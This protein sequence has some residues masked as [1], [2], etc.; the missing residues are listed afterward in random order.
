MTSVWNQLGLPHKGWRCVEVIDLRDDENSPEETDY[1]TCEMC[2]NERIRFVHILEHD[3]F[4]A[5]LKVGCVCAENLT[6]DYINP[7]SH[8]NKLKNKANR[9]AK[10]LTRKWRVSSQGNKFLNIDGH[11]LCVF[12]DKFRSGHWKYKI[13]KKFSKNS[14]TSIT[15]AKLALFEEF[16]RLTQ[17]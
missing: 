6:E 3:D 5:Q 8:E 10:W 7:R 4:E 15:E 2:G 11:N 16:W 1:A 12:L 14:Y 9:K 17:E 13:D